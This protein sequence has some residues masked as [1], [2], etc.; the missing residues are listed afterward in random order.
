MKKRSQRPDNHTYTIVFRGLASH[1]DFGKSLER[2]LTVY[3]SMCALDSPVK[4]SLIHTNAAL[5]V[6]AQAGDL[7][8]MFGI[9]ARLPRSGPRAADNITFTIIF[10]ALSKLVHDDSESDKDG[11]LQVDITKRQNAVLQGRRMWAEI[12]ERWNVGDMMLDE[13]LV[14]AVGRLLL[15]ADVPQDLD[16]VLSLLE[17]TMGI[18]RQTPRCRN[19][20]RA[21]AQPEKEVESPAPGNIAL[22]QTTEPGRKPSADA[23]DEFVPG[24]EYLPSPS[25]RS[26]FYAIPSRS[27][28]SLVVDACTRL[29]L[30]STAQDYW[31]LLTGSPYHIVPDTANYHMYLRLL[32]AQRASRKCVELVQE[33]RDGLGAGSTVPGAAPKI[34][35]VRGESGYVNASTFRIALGACKRDIQNPFVV[36]HA[37]KLV[38]IMYDCLPEVDIRVMTTY[39]EIIRKVTGGDWREMHDALMGTELGTRLLKSLFLYGT[40]DEDK[41]GEEFLERCRDLDG[42]LRT[43]IGAYDQ[44]LQDKRKMLPKDK[45]RAF[46]QLATLASWQTDVSCHLGRVIG[47]RRTWDG[48]R[49]TRLKLPEPNPEEPAWK[50]E[51][52]VARMKEERYTK[53]GANKRIAM[54]QYLRRMQ[55]GSM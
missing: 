8:A 50:H 10:N 54:A 38:R 40:A 30:F 7:D 48:G 36:K 27:T 4:P 39:V 18:P 19:I 2:A 29:R 26:M 42:F 46:K 33:M 34:R 24:D 1:A 3:H 28:L 22:V 51:A 37:S 49:H 55:N 41:K 32:R 12:I 11:S 53:G 47:R 16:D 35:T 9:A 5:K 21:Q 23:E 31:G 6:C 45:D 52:L 13:S 15:L 14:C 43:L 25:V 17:Q 20:D 44:L